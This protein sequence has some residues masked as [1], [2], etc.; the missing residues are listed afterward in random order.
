MRVV[1][2]YWMCRPCPRVSATVVEG[3]Q[4]Y[5]VSPS[6]GKGGGDELFVF[7][8]LDVW[9]FLMSTGV[10]NPFPPLELLQHFL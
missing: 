9:A 4:I 3:L 8:K 5:L 2:D 6:L 1:D 7:G 10:W